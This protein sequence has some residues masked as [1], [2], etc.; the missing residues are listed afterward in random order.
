MWRRGVVPRGREQF[1]GRGRAGRVRA[2]LG[3]YGLAYGQL[4]DVLVPAPDEVRPSFFHTGAGV[5]ML[6]F[7]RSIAWWWCTGWT[8]RLGVSLMTGICIG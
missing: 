8:P 5:H 4:L 2:G 6:G 7:I 1:T 3:W